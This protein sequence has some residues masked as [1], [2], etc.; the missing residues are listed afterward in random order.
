MRGGIRLLRDQKVHAR[1]VLRARTLPGI[2][3]EVYALLT[4]YQLIKITIAD[5]TGTIPGADPNRA[6]FSMAL[7]PARDQAIQAAGVP[8]PSSTSS[9]PSAA[10]SWT[11]PRACA[12]TVA[13]T[14]PPSASTSS[15][16]RPSVHSSRPCPLVPERWRDRLVELMGRVADCVRDRRL[17]H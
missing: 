15:R 17:A 6:S 2:D 11:E 9:A 1:R 14:R 16:Q 10:R 12:S 13:P 8:T 3:Q 7:Q 4:A 5:A